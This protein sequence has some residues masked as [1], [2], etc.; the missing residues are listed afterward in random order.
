MESIKFVATVTELPNNRVKLQALHENNKTNSDTLTYTITTL[1]TDLEVYSEVLYWQSFW[2][3]LILF[4]LCRIN[5]QFCDFSPDPELP[6]LIYKPSEEV[7][8]WLI[9]RSK[10]LRASVQA[11]DTLKEINS[12][13]Q[14]YNW[15]FFVFYCDRDNSEPLFKLNQIRGIEALAFWWLEASPLLTRMSAIINLRQDTWRR[16]NFTN[17]EHYY[18]RKRK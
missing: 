17:K 14:T 2:A 6:A 3:H 13:L 12:Y 7:T 4:E 8:A 11:G 1:L 15:C 18:R 16:L 5:S 10:S 9:S